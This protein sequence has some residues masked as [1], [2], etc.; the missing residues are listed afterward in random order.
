VTAQEEPELHIE[1]SVLTN[2]KRIERWQD[3]VIGR[4]GVILTKG[5]AKSVFLPQ[6][7]PE[8]GW[9]LKQML[10]HLSMKAGLPANGYLEGATF[11][12]FQAQVFSE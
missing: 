4:D 5:W 11:E 12:I 8:Q 7:A 9:N 2:P 6:V 1:I 3:I 10:E